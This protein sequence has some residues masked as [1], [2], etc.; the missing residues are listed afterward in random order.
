VIPRPQKTTVHCCFLSVT[1]SQ[2]GAQAREYCFLIILKVATFALKL[3]VHIPSAALLVCFQRLSIALKYAT[4]FFW[5][6]TCYFCSLIF[7]S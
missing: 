2:N 7:W 4:I 3:I 5:N 6:D 1:E